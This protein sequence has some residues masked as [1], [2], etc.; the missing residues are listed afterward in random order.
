MSPQH[1][2]PCTYSQ[3]PLRDKQGMGQQPGGSRRGEIHPVLYL[4]R[5]WYFQ[6][7]HKFQSEIVGRKETIKTLFTAS[8][9]IS[10]EKSDSPGKLSWGKQAQSH[11]RRGGDI[12]DV[13]PAL[14]KRG[15]MQAEGPITSVSLVLCNS[16]STSLC[17]GLVRTAVHPHFLSNLTGLPP[18]SPC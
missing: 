2:L 3:G 11:Q 7:H 8:P 5:L 13:W 6:E 10:L 12:A 4:G 17:C 16:T 9:R 15:H 1:P 14:P 18:H